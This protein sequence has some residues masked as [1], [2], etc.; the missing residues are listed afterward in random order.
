MTDKHHEKLFRDPIHN[1]ISF[2]MSD[3]TDR[4]LFSLVDTD[5]VQRL[6][7]IGQL[8]LANFVYH[9]AEH[10]RFGH[11]VGTQHVAKRMFDSAN[12]RGDRFERAVTRAAALLHDIGHAAFSHAFESGMSKICNF[13]HEA[14]TCA[15][16]LR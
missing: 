13:D 7:R 12:P 11:S 1:V 8:G 3:E 4:M 2:D 16:I 6:R 10:S 14:M 5:V 15:Y 9:G